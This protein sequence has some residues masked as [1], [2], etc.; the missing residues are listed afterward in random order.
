MA[1]WIRC[2]SCGHIYENSL[3]KCPECGR[4]AMNGK[5]L[6]S[7][8]GA[9]FVLMVAL[10]GT[11]IGVFAGGGAEIKNSGESDTA[12]VAEQNLGNVLSGTVELTISKDFLEFM[13]EEFDYTLT[14]EQ[15]DS[16]FTDIKKNDDGS[17]TYTIKKK[18]YQAYVKELKGT[19]AQGF[20]E[21][22]ADDSFSSVKK[23]EYTDRFEKITITAD[24]EQFENSFDSL[25]I[26]SC[27]LSS[28]MYQMFDIDAAG[29][30]IIEVKDSA[31]GEVFRTETYP[32]SE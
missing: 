5:T 29:K 23:I 11:L 7:I 12:I 24:K 17:A 4:F 21:M 32:K 30:C 10:T 19:T 26:M 16:G 14:Q 28:C 1:K 8:I 13:G 15:R 31:T 27:G 25:C 20:D 18:E 3:N 2:K 22:L 9:L 6:F